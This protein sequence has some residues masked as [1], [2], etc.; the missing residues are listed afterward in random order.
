MAMHSEEQLSC[1][2]DKKPFTRKSQSLLKSLKGHAKWF[3]L[4]IEQ[5]FKKEKACLIIYISNT[6]T[7]RVPSP[8]STPL[9]TLPE[10][11]MFASFFSSHLPLRI[12]LLLFHQCLRELLS[13]GN[14]STLSGFS[15]FPLFPLLQ[16][17]REDSVLPGSP[18]IGREEDRLVIEMGK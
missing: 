8:R 15:Q 5:H 17:S 2:V 11:G 12:Y 1:R 3:L 13:R 9:T 18:S 10:P 14:Q 4:K 16:F 7:S 6:V